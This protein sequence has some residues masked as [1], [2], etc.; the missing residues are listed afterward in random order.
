M[1]V[2]VP[3]LAHIMPRQNTVNVTVPALALHVACI[4][5]VLHDTNGT[6]VIWVIRPIEDEPGHVM[7]TA[8]LYNG[9]IQLLFLRMLHVFQSCLT[10]KVTFGS[11]Y[12]LCCP[13]L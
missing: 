9:Q 13:L 11:K 10:L 7:P 6:H 2:T 5:R 4:M 1:N 8:S 12:S 3:T